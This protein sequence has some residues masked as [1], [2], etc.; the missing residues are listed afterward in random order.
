MSDVQYPG[1]ARFVLTNPPGLDGIG[2]ADTARWE[3]RRGHDADDRIHAHWSQSLGG[4]RTPAGGHCSH[5]PEK[6]RVFVGG[7]KRHGSCAKVRLRRRAL[8]DMT[9]RRDASHLDSHAI[10][11]YQPLRCREGQA[12]AGSP[13]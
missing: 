3:S 2:A 4:P 13:D 6:A 1:C 10:L 11:G 12:L 7:G 8:Q 9:R 5:E